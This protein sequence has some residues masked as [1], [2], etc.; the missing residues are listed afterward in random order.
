M[1]GPAYRRRPGRAF[2]FARLGVSTVV[3]CLLLVALAFCAGCEEEG[4]DADD[5]VAISG[6]ARLFV[7][8]MIA[9]RINVYFDGAFI[10]AVEAGGGR[11]WDVPVGEHTVE[12]RNAEID[13]GAAE[14]TY[15]FV[16]GMTTTVTC[17]WAL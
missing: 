3:G 11:G 4:D 2:R 1:L 8:S 14:D 12:M 13:A 9:Q 10:G 7:I 15:T 6:D 16:A 17:D 5:P